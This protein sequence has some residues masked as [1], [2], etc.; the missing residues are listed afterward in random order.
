MF[1][2]GGGGGN[3]QNYLCIHTRTCTCISVIDIF[4]LYQSFQILFC[5]CTRFFLCPYIHSVFS[6]VVEFFSV[7]P[8]HTHVGKVDSLAL[9]YARE[10]RLRIKK[11]HSS[12]CQYFPTMCTRMQCHSL[13]RS[14][15]ECQKGCFRFAY[16]S[17]FSSSAK[18]S[19]V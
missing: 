8:K 19:R 4:S 5:D 16:M 18:V 12:F 11:F 6:V 7:F 1:F 2:F 9:N 15:T 17:S 3:N 14:V 13:A 10:I